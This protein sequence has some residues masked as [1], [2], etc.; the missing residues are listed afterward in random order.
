YLTDPV[1]RRY[2]RS[3]IA[4]NTLEIG[5]GDSATYGG[6]FLWLDSP[7]AAALSVD[8]LDGGPVAS[9]RARRGVSISLTRSRG[10]AASMCAWLIISAPPSRRAP[11][12]TVLRWHGRRT[13]GAIPG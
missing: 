1:A 6:S 11:T 7:N 8:G 9:W 4:H 12:V 10:R 13:D 5:G 2:F 3:T